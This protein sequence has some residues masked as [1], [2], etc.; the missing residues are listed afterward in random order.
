MKS[1]EKINQNQQD[2]L[3]K[4]SQKLVTSLNHHITLPQIAKLIVPRLADYCRIA[5]VD[6]DKK[7]KEIAINHTDPTKTILVQ[8]LFNSYK[9]MSEATYGVPSILRSG[10]SEI[11]PKINTKTLAPYRKNTQLMS[12]IKKI[13]LKSYMGVPLIARGK[14]LGAITFSSVQPDRYFTKEDLKFAEE[15]ANRIAL[16][17]DNVRLFEDVQQKLK[18][19][20]QYEEVHQR[21]AAIVES[22][23]DAIISKTLKGIIT[24]WN[25]G[26]EQM[27]GYTAEE[28]VGKHINL[29]IPKHLHKEEDTIIDNIKHG[30]HITHFETVRRRKDGTLLNISLSISPLR[31]K[32]GM[33]I[34]ASKI[35]RDITLRKKREENI[36]FISE[37]SKI[38]SSSLDYQTTLNK[39]AR[40][41]VPKIA[42]WCVIDMLSPERR[43]VGVALAHR[44]IKIIK[45][46]KEYRKKYPPTPSQ[47]IK[48]GVAELYPEVTQ[49]MLTS[50]IKDKKQL[51]ELLSMGGFSSVM[52]VPIKE[53][54]KPIGTISFISSESKRKYTKEDLAM[55]DELA[56]RA[57]LAIENAKLYKQSQDALR[58]RDE[59]I[60]VASHELK[61][62]LTSLRI[63]TQLLAQ[64][65]TDPKKPEWQHFQKLDNQINRLT[66]LVYDLLDVSKI[67]TGRLDF[68]MT[69]FDISA[70]V[71]ET[72]SNMELSAPSHKLVVS[73]LSPIHVFADPDRIT[74]VLINLIDNAV[75]YS[76]DARQVKISSQIQKDQVKITIQD[77]GVGIDKKNQAKIFE[78]FFQVNDPSAPAFSG[79]GMGLYISSEIIRRHGGKIAVKSEHGKGATFYFTLPLASRASM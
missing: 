72:V 48:T 38:L 28:A 65:F 42:D 30:R 60:S 34:G 71:T 57:S 29:I 52:I 74:Q 70:L 8:D 12:V 61:T 68:H 17:L 63:Y 19:S 37:A 26:A 33:I 56:A 36:K 43:L 11:L 7:I 76:P 32:T 73:K 2:V 24:S 1:R 46:A 40:L 41:A 78:R 62:P 45:R 58:L 3:A 55:A 64:R 47:V 50:S 66:Q 10:K 54:R 9:D 39:V 6:K 25:R 21:L 15:L 79:L 51:R 49:D 4:V 5:I 77:F 59:F 14:V 22:S 27:F 53:R 16:T 75:K 20:R 35:A 69:K 67:Q 44:D 31:Y 18:E 23:D 13:G